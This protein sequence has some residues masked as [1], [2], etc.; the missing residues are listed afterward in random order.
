MA[1]RPK[2]LSICVG[3]GMLD[4]GLRLAVDARTICYVE[5][6][7]PAAEIL[8][9]RIADGSLDNAPI[10]SDLATFD[11]RP[12][13]GLVD[14][15]AGGIPCQPF[16]LAGQ[17][18]GNKDERAIAP[19]VLRVVEECAPA[20]VF[21]E[22]VPAWVRGGFAA[23]FL[24]RLHDM[25]YDIADP[26]VVRAS[27]FGAPH[28]RERVFVMA[29]RDGSIGRIARNAERD[30]GGSA[31]S[32]WPLESGG[33]RGALGDAQRERLAVGESAPEP[34]SFPS[35]W[36]P[37]P[38]DDWSGIDEGRWPSRAKPVVRRMAYGPA[39]RLDRLRA[40]GNGCVPLVVAYAFR[41][42]LRSLRAAGLDQVAD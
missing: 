25:G 19:T 1:V 28:R 14:I 32:I 18:A 33:S 11:A 4:L 29:Y 34:G 39:S 20:V 17:R 8:A 40:L 31:D 21:L 27:D 10:W 23:P 16:S 37:G 7:I 15:L 6:D 22:N 24:A 42:A 13:R 5:R 12:W 3:V 30:N 35:A 2:V 41:V 9:T 36:P 38:A 26:V